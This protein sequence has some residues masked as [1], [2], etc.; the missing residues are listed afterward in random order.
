VQQE[1]E[2]LLQEITTFC[3]EHS[4][5]R[6]IAIAT[7]YMQ[8]VKSIERRR[9]TALR[10]HLDEQRLRLIREA[11]AQMQHYQDHPVDP[12]GADPEQ[13]DDTKSSE[14]QSEEASNLARKS[15]GRFSERATHCL[16]AWYAQHLTDPYISLPEADKLGKKAR[17][18]SK[19]VKKWMDNRRNRDNNS[20]KNGRSHPYR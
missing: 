2:A 15:N 17:L 4:S 13:N 18:T 3:R 7:D 12:Q 16:E 8:Q 1:H 9:E 19:E 14:N 10:N 20:K 11:R 6:A 5:P